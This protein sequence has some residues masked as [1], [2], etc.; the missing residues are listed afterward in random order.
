MVYLFFYL[1]L[2]KNESEYVWDPNKVWDP[3]ESWSQATQQPS[4]PSK[5]SNPQYQIE[6]QYNI[7][8]NNTRSVISNPVP[9][10]NRVTGSSNL[11]VSEDSFPTWDD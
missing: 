7:H 2:S 3:S 8:S 6:Q 4:K 9:K 10:T 11:F 5:P 1:F